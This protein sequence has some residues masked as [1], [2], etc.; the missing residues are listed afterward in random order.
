MVHIAFFAPKGPGHVNPML[1]LATELVRRGHRVT[2]AAPEVF[3]E[4]IEETGAEYVPAPSTWSRSAGAVPQMHGK[5]FVRAMGMLLGETKVVHAS[6]VNREAPDLVVHDGPLAWWGRMLARQWGVPAVETWPN[7]VSNKHWSLHHDYT[8][9]NALSPRFLLMILRIG[10]YLKSQGITDVGSFLQGTGAADRLVM[11]PRAF[12]YEGD[13]F[14]EGYRFVGPGLTGRA[15]QSDWSPPSDA[16]VVLVSLGTSYNDRPDFYRMVAQSAA[17]L[18]WQV[19]MAIG[20]TDP[21]DLGVLPPNVEVHPQV[22]Q[23]AVLRHASVFVT[24]AGMGGTMEGLDAGVPMVALPQMAEQRANADRVQALGLGLALDPEQLD[25]DNLWK[26][27][28]RVADDPAVRERL[29]WMRGEI[30]E[31]GGAHAAADAVEEVLERR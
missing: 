11:L 12:Q 21:A 7:L 5:E 14:R 23:L 18:P 26:A 2:F 9:F 19:V 16:P 13:T 28:G 3:A 20:A 22:P 27:V 4:R 1:G 29:A 17:D 31:A 15:F 30:S 8:T 10:R 6:Q 24:H 25:T